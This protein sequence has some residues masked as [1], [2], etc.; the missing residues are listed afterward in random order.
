M[1]RVVF[2]GN[3]PYD[4]EEDKLIPV[5]STVGPI[6]GFRLMVDKETGKSKG[7]AFCEYHDH[8]TAASAVRNLNGT[9]VN[10]RPLRIDLADSDPFFEGKTTKSGRT[11]PEDDTRPNRYG[12]GGDDKKFDPLA[13]LP[14]GIP[15]PPGSDA[16]TTITNSLAAVP[17][18]QMLD[19]L[20]QMKAY[21]ISSPEH[22]RLLF[23]AHP[24]LAYAFF[25]AMVLNN[26]VDPAILERM[27]TAAAAQAPA[28]PP[29]PVPVPAPILPTHSQ[30]ASY[31]TA[32]PPPP[33]HQQPYYGAQKAPPQ[34]PYSQQQP[35]HQAVYP[36]P[37]PPPCAPVAP[38]QQADI[39]EEQKAM[40]MQILSLSQDQINALPPQERT[41]VQQLR[42]QFMGT[43]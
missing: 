4:V 25:Q 5:F 1:S 43:G 22:A 36:P 14:S 34:A 41:T 19:I 35:V 7:Y 24:Q 38:A 10:G 6:A 3:V 16:L 39:P 28:P 17:P 29:A 31:R 32:G 11:R 30:P 23:N 26:L 8:D 9:E 37:Q 21:V 18:A 13:N 40:L 15:I 33:Q 42:A 12:G 20:G 2:V 27:I